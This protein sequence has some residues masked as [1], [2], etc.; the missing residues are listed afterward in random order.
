MSDISCEVIKDLIPLYADNVCSQDSKIIVE[1][2]IKNCSE[3]ADEL[4][5]ITDKESSIK[6][7]PVDSEELKMAGKKFKK[8]KKKAV[9]KGVII[10]LVAVLLSGVLLVPDFLVI[11]AKG[12]CVV[13]NPKVKMNIKDQ[14]DGDV[15]IENIKINLPEN[16]T[17]EKN[18][19]SETTVYNITCSDSDETDNS[20]RITVVFT[21]NEIEDIYATVSSDIIVSWFENKGIKELGFNTSDRLEDYIYYLFS[22]E[23]PPTYKFFSSL[24]KKA[25][26]FAYYYG[27]DLW[28]PNADGMFDFETEQYK[29]YG[30]MLSRMDEEGKT[31]SMYVFTVCSKGITIIFNGQFKKTEIESIMSSMVID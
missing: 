25:A 3:C 28:V 12:N 9:I 4:E 2:H 27:Y 18:E 23:E 21:N 13:T 14:K 20:R 15:Q 24:G 1:E 11:F 8:T 30:Y 17:S 19:N 22:T 6:A 5:K 26:A 7:T 29:C 16:Y 10:G 31:K